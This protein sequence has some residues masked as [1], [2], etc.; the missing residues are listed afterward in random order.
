MSALGLASLDKIDD[1]NWLKTLSLISLCCPHYMRFVKGSFSSRKS[2]FGSYKK[3]KING[4]GK[5]WRNLER[6]KMSFVAPPSTTL[7]R[8]IFCVILGR[9]VLLTLAVNLFLQKHFYFAFAFALLELF[10]QFSCY[11][12]NF[13]LSIIQRLWKGKLKLWTKKKQRWIYF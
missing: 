6:L 10:D 3:T 7:L 4:R 12:F 13:S 5:G 2:K 9:S 1:N 8:N 11:A